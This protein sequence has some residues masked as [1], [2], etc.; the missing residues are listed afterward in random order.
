MLDTMKWLYGIELLQNEEKAHVRI[1][2]KLSY[3]L[4]GHKM[5][6][7]TSVPFF[8]VWPQHTI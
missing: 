5:T 4:Y 6:I 2:L 1:S 8:D 7:A 3:Y